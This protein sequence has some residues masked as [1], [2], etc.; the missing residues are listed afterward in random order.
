MDGK[1]YFQRVQDQTSTR[2]W[3]N[4]VTREQAHV[5][6]D[7]GAVGCTQ[8]P[9]YPWKMIDDPKEYSYAIGILDKILITE[10]DDNEALV[11][12]QK[13]LVAKIAE[14]FLP[15]YESSGCKNG[16]VS[17]QGDP[18]K[19]DTRHYSSLRTL[20]PSGRTKYNGKNPGY[21]RWS[22]SNRNSGSR[23][24]SH[25]CYRGNGSKTGIGCL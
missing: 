3:I 1:N 23:K 12:L 21:R 11:K 20:Q 4:N 7:A 25:K 16:Y 8:N 15:M 22:E 6:I 2:F 9:S 5:A 18:F 17:I 19:E 13:E 10:K 24:G 14:I